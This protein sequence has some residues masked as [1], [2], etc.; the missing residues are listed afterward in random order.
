M[1]KN[2]LSNFLLKMS[3]TKIKLIIGV[4]KNLLS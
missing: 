1:K 3:R 2:F 4:E